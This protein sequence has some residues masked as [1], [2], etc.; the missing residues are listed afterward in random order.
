MSK[1][2][3]CFYCCNESI[4]DILKSVDG[5]TITIP[6]EVMSGDMDLCLHIKGIV[7]RETE[8]HYIVEMNDE[9]FLYFNE[10]KETLNKAIPLIGN[11][12]DFF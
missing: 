3:S 11:W 10:Q 6:K 8:T 7:V 4:L 2:D 12:K 9:D 1:F 5:Q